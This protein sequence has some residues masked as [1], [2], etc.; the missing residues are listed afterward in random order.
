[1]RKYFQTKLK[2]FLER[3]L[4][5]LHRATNEIEYQQRLEQVRFFLHQIM[6]SINDKWGGM[7]IIEGGKFNYFQ[8]PSGELPKY[9]F[10]LPEIPLYVVVGNIL[11]ADWEQ[12]RQRGI[13]RENW[14]NYQLDLSAIEETTPT[15]S[16]IGKAAAPKI[17]VLR[18]NDPINHLT[19]AEK[20]Q[21]ESK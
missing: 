11:S 12:A 19:L 9:D 13:T 2:I 8:L 21:E 3:W 5:R 16:T 6:P 18:W 17:I 1:M 10:A 15:L 14:E 20:L 7:A 4:Y